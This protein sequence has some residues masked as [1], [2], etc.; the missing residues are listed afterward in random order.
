MSGIK[1]NRSRFVGVRFTEDEYDKIEKRANNTTCIALS[2]YIRRILL[3]KPVTGYTRNRSLDDFMAEMIL[4]RNELNAIGHNYNQAVRK[5]HTCDTVP[6]I[7]LWLF[8]NEQGMG[9][10]IS[11]INEIKTKMDN[12]SDQWLQ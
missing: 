10:L 7:K 11:K 8:S 9:N 6:E 5:L 3:N 12:I 4:L 2:E 1:S